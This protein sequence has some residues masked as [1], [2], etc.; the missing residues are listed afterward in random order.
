MSDSSSAEEA[1]PI[2]EDIEKKFGFVPNLAREMAASPQILELYFKGNQFLD[3]SVLCESEKQMVMLLV[4]IFNECIYCQ[5]AH[6]AGAIR[7]EIKKKE[8]EVLK[9]GQELSTERGKALCLATRLLL[10]KK[11]CLSQD[12]LRELEKR[13]VDR[14]QLFEIIGIISLKTI[15]NYI[16]HI[17]GTEIDDA[18]K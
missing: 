1:Q 17:A 5:A 3:K 11:G 8:I 9:L 4:S 12:N 10:T 15:S 18:F 6:T 16:N 7:A 2:L 13:G 14:R